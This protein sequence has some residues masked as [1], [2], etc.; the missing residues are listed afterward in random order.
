[1]RWRASGATCSASA[2]GS[3]DSR[4]GPAALVEQLDVA[5]L[6][7]RLLRRPSLRGRR[8]RGGFAAA[9]LGRVDRCFA[10]LVDD[11]VVLQAR[12]G[13][14]RTNP[15]LRQ[16]APLSI[17]HEHPAEIL[18]GRGS[19]REGVEA[20]ARARRGARRGLLRDRDPFGRRD[21][22]EAR[23]DHRAVWCTPSAAHGE[24]NKDRAVP[25]KP[26]L[27]AATPTTATRG[28][29][30]RARTHSRTRRCRCSCTTTARG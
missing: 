6:G 3:T 29:S 14:Y 17:R 10:C 25:I 19:G 27:E 18:L 23:L 7:Q 20:L 8:S 22:A 28:A 12:S 26:T 11:E 15:K 1:M 2:G 16:T 4:T 9:R 13:R 30:G 5:E 21:R 24:S